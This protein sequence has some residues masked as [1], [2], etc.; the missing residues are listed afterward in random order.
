MMTQNRICCNL[1]RQKNTVK[2]ELERRLP[3][4]KTAS[5]SPRLTSR[6]SR[7]NVI[8]S[9]PAGPDIGG[10]PALPR[11]EPTA[12]PLAPRREHSAAAL[13]LHACAE[14]VRLRATAASRVIG[15]LWPSHPP[16]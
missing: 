7:G 12:P 5:N 6:A 10:L 9:L 15:A 16:F 13:R 3:A 11:G 2:G 8:A 1:L 4:R 14:T